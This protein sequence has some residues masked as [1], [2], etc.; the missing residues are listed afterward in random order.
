MGCR[1][2]RGVGGAAHRMSTCRLLVINSPF[3]ETGF[4]FAG[5]RHFVL[6]LAYFQIEARVAAGSFLA[7]FPCISGRSVLFAVSTQC[8]EVVTWLASDRRC[9]RATSERVQ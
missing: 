4:A 2:R 5:A 7:L 1:G 6:E 8:G 9:H 3:D